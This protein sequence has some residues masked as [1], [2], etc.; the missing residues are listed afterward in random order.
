M[1]KKVIHKNVVCWR[2]QMRYQS[3]CVFVIIS[4]CLTSLL[5]GFALL[6]LAN[7]FFSTP[8]LYFSQFKIPY[9]KIREIPIQFMPWRMLNHSPR[10]FE[11]LLVTG[12][13][14]LFSSLRKRNSRSSNIE[15]FI[16]KF[17]CF[18]ESFQSIISFAYLPFSKSCSE[19][20]HCL[21]FFF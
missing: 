6:T 3:K 17:F 14:F 1:N 4:F 11:N 7:W 21:F 20:F 16:V 12:S 10:C 9:H 19:Y 5:F 8:Y 13:Y 15:S 18:F 2:N